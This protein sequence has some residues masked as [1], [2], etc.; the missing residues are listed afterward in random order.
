[1]SVHIAIGTPMGVAVNVVA[2]DGLAS[3]RL[4]APPPIQ[5]SPVPVPQPGS[6]LDLV[7]GIDCTSSMGPYIAAAKE[8]LLSIATRFQQQYP[9]EG[10]LR[11]G[12]VAYQDHSPQPAAYITKV[13]SLSPDISAA[14]TF[15]N[16]LR[17]YGGGDG[18]EAVGA[19][20]GKIVESEW[21]A[22]ATKVAVLIADAPP[23]GLGEAGDG[24]SQGVPNSTDPFVAVD[25][26]AAAGISLYPVGCLPALNQYRFAIPFFVEAARKTGG[27]A[28]ALSGARRLGDVILGA[29]LVEIGL[30]DL[31]AE[32]QRRVAAVAEA[33]PAW[34]TRQ[35]HVQVA[36]DLQEEG[37]VYRSLAGAP[38]LKDKTKNGAL[39]ADVTNLSAARE[40]APKAVVE[41]PTVDD[42]IVDRDE[43]PVY[44]SLAASAAD[45]DEFADDDELPV[46][47]SASSEPAYRS[48]AGPARKRAAR[49]AEPESDAP[50]VTESSISVDFLSSLL[51]AA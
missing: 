49:V 17:A 4:P 21:R 35:V 7:F 14:R 23:H 47:R 11:V 6:V 46:Y 32:A 19:A 24:F 48:F 25:A 28:V 5:H 33:N 20:L 15:I 30:T 10:R 50:L 26:L 38:D 42:T 13:H 39:F 29:G 45:D 2:A 3:D 37:M 9:G 36:A 41:A 1:M 12:V 51:A 31:R 18:P 44:R 40:K 34:T 43:F 22:D 16:E 27:K 8:S